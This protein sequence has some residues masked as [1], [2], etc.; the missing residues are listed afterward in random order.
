MNLAEFDTSRMTSAEKAELLELLEA[1]N[2]LRMEN[3]LAHYKPYQKQKDFHAEGGRTGIRERLLMAGNQLGKSYSAGYETAMHLTG[4]YPSW[5]AGKRFTSPTAGW[6][7]SL[8][9]QGTRDTVQRM[10]LG[11]PGSWG[12]GAIPMDAIVE[13]KRSAHGVSDAVETILVRHSGGGLSTITLKT[14]DQG[15]ERWQGETLDFVWFDEEPP[16]DLYF[17]GLTRTNATAGVVWMTFTPLLGMSSIVKR[18]LI[19]K[20]PG[21]SITSM[22]IDD[23]EH[24]TA[25]QRALIIAAYP[26]H[27]RDARAKGIPTMGSGRVFPIAEESITVQQFPIPYYWPRICGLDFGWDHPFAAA[28]LAMDPD[29]D[30]IYVYDCFKVREQTPVM[31]AATMRGKG[32]WIPVAWPHDGLQHDKGSGT[33]LKTLYA[34]QGVRMLAEKATWPDGGNSVEK[35]LMD[36]MDRMQTGRFKVFAH[37]AD[38]FEEFRLFHRKDGKLVK[39]GDDILSAARYALMM[40]RFARVQED[41]LGAAM[42]FTPLG[43]LDD[44]AGY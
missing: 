31:H 44:V 15:R 30:T 1:R 14:Y 43:V 33:E 9:S 34:A 26:A 12:T 5:W 42:T 6:A 37:L 18:F 29:T 24:Y 8:T 19:D 35:G 23:A 4:R 3:Q 36:M 32:Q 27:E 21:T 22:T 7:A 40:I 16:A 39:E 20:A 41:R 10:L 2:K 38:F 17:E 28:W 25:E 11:R 13:I